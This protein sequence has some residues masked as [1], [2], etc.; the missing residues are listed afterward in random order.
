MKIKEIKD[1][2]ILLAYWYNSLK[3]GIDQVQNA[4]KLLAA[5]FP[6]V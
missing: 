1:K 4:H 6:A 5:F 2:A 3:F